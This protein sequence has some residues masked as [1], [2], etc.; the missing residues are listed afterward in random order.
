MNRFKKGIWMAAAAL[1]LLAS[2]AVSAAQ[3]EMTMYYPIAVGGKPY[4]LINGL[5]GEF[6]AQNPDIKVKAVYYGNYDDTRT[7]CLAA[8]KAGEK[9]QMS[10]L[11]SIDIF[12]LIDADVIL[13]WEEVAQTDLDRAWLNG[14]YPALM[15][16]SMAGGKTYGVPF[17][18]STI[19][20]YY[21]KDA[22][23]E[24][25]LDPEKPPATWD[26]LVS[27]GQKLVKRDAGGQVTRWGLSIPSTGYPYWM[28]QCLAIQ[29]G[30]ELMNKAGNE[31]YFNHPDEVAALQFWHDMAYKHEIM[32]K[33]STDWGTLRQQFL[34]GATAMMWHTTGNLTP[35]RDGAKFDFGVA[36]L[37]ANKRRGSPTGGGNFYVF[38]NTTAEERAA[39]LKFVQFMTSPVNSAKWSIGT[40]YVATTPTAYETDLLKSYVADFPAAVVARDQFEYAV[41]EFSTHETARVKKFLDDAIQAVLSGN[42]TPQ[43]ALDQAQQG[44]DRILRR[45]R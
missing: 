23:R 1:V 11:F 19:V 36:M 21:N 8:V 24:A 22:F 14:F 39:V 44:A 29:N 34:G 31:V 6:E 5:I 16:N 37:P 2:G 28:F 13:P 20:M 12:D 4:E 32:S 30:M 43:Q 40:G 42:A 35:V 10:V 17:Q 33:G 38:K 26:E 3:I 7:K 45:Y 15:A 27:M 25:G 18:R 41:A 9:V